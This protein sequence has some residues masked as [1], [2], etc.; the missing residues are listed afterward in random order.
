MAAAAVVVEN[1]GE[2]EGGD[3]RR[4]G[5]EKAGRSPHCSVSTWECQYS[6]LSI[7]GGRSAEMRE[8]KLGAVSHS[9]V[10]PCARGAARVRVVAVCAGRAVA[11]RGGTGRA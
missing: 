7:L 1:G 3:G 2:G 9:R 10:A 8:K 11:G 5:W 4:R 6:S